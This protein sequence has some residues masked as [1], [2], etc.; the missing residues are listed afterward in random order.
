M[1]IE[2]IIYGEL[3]KD[4]SI[5]GRTEHAQDEPRDGFQII[6]FEYGP[7]DKFQLEQ[8]ATSEKIGTGIFLPNSKEIQTII[9]NSTGELRSVEKIPQ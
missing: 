8:G 2:G 9:I 6:I 4:S 5:T 3:I 1:Q 7:R